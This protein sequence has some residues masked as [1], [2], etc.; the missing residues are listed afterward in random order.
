MKISASKEV[1]PSKLWAQDWW[2]WWW[3]SCLFTIARQAPLSMGFPR[4]EYG[5]G[6]PFPAPGAL[7]DPGIRPTFP[8]SSVVGGFFT[9]EP[10]GKPGGGRSE[11]AWLGRGRRSVRV[12]GCPPRPE[13][14]LEEAS[15]EEAGEELRWVGPENQSE[16]ADALPPHSCPT[17]GS[18]PGPAWI[19]APQASLPTP[20]LHR[21]TW[22]PRPL[23]AH[24]TAGRRE[25]KGGG[26]APPPAP[27]PSSA[28]RL[29]TGSP[30]RSQR[31][32]AQRLLLG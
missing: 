26:V 10:P 11:C 17:P 28:F 5:S 6:L 12:V 25:E 14:C 18:S 3:F 21:T 19:T 31:R 1:R 23:C 32:L 8:V 13:A 4:Q 9:A 29:S 24:P 2:W 15:R 27:P 20:G 16:S 22:P 30:P 7:P